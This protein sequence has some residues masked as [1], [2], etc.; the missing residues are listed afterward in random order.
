[1]LTSEISSNIRNA[2][3][4]SIS[5]IPLALATMS[6]IP[7]RLSEMKPAISSDILQVRTNESI[8]DKSDVSVSASFIITYAIA[9]AG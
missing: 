2:L 6:Q 7:L 4:V 3:Y 1:M 5:N 9:Y 8:D